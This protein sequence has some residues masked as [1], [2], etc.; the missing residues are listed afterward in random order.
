MKELKWENHGSV[1]IGRNPFIPI[2]RCDL[3]MGKDGKMWMCEV[4]PQI[5]VAKVTGKWFVLFDTTE[6]GENG[7]PFLRHEVTDA[8]EGDFWKM[9]R[10]VYHEKIVD[11][12][13][14]QYVIEEFMDK[15]G[16][17]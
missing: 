11:Y 16:I 13:E 2:Q 15:N 12:E 8:P 6:E 4:R 14:I 3:G 1:A 7:C 10:E 9:R 5:N 17:K